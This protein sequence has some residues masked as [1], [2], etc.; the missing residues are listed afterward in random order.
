MMALDQA[1]EKRGMDQGGS[2]GE[3]SLPIWGSFQDS[4]Q[5]WLTD[6]RARVRERT[7]P[8]VLPLTETKKVEG[9]VDLLQVVGRVG[10]KKISL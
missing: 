10:D 5:G 4:Q 6:V 9:E 2:P 7:N 1:R 3:A 8:C